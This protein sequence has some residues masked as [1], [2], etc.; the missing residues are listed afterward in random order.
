MGTV[1]SLSFLILGIVQYKDAQIEHTKA[2][3]ALLKAKKVE[4]EIKATGTA[5]GK[6]LLAL[7]TM[8]GTIITFEVMKFFPDLMETSA[9]SLFEAIELKN[10]EIHD[11]YQ[12][13]SL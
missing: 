10:N 5:L 1:L 2:N 8:N 6:V 11:M 3:E 12:V 4:K 9:S 13:K 7:S